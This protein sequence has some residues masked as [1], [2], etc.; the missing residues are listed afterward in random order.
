MAKMRVTKSN[1]SLNTALDVCENWFARLDKQRSDSQQ[2][3]EIAAKRRKGEMT[4]AEAELA[5]KRITGY[6]PT[7]YDGG[8]LEIAVKRLI[9]EIGKLECQNV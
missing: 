1:M 8:Q 5:V 4:Y 3:Q 2:L 7:M 6:S 9:E